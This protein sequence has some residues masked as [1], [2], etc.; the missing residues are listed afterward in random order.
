MCS[1]R[2]SSSL[3][4][5]P[6][7]RQMSRSRRR[8]RAPSSARGSRSGPGCALTASSAAA[9]IDAAQERGVVPDDGV[10]H[11]VRQREQDHEVERVELGQRALPRRPER[12]HQQQVDQPP[13]GRPSRSARPGGCRCSARR[14]G[15]GWPRGWA[16]Q[17]GASV[18]SPAISFLSMTLPL[19]H[20]I[21]R[22]NRGGRKPDEPRP[23]WRARLQ[24]LRHVPRL[25]RAGVAY[26]AALRGGDPGAARRPV[27]GAARGALDR[28]ADRGRGG[29]RG[30]RGR[31]GR[32]VDWT[33]L[34]ELLAL[35]LAIA[36]VGEGAGPAVGA[37][38]EPAGRPLR[39]PHQRRAHAPRGHARSGAV[40]GRRALRQAR[41]GPAADGRD[42]SGSSPCCSP[43]C[44]T[45][46]RS[47]PW[48]RRSRCTC[49]GCWCCW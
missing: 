17:R 25:L 5:P 32:R 48:R 33:R 43:R 22:P 38:R 12:E 13:A 42:G 11:R 39:Q 47:S 27:A 15:R 31:P 46:S 6:S 4:W 29:A 37:A 41:A 20:P 2:I 7:I 26:R 23:G 21:V 28:Q 3:S 49:R 30:R 8:R 9:P 36:L 16:S 34:A 44:R 1:R 14:G 24:A 10:L 35:E 18:G 40:R 19:G 45:P